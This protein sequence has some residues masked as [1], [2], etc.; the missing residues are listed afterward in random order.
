[1]KVVLL[2]NVP[3]VGERYQVK[4]VAG[5]YARNVLIRQGLALPATAE[6]LKK[7]KSWQA[8]QSREKANEEAWAEEVASKLE[9]Y[10]LSLSGKASPEG[11]LFAGLGTQ[12][13]VAALKKEQG[14]ELKPEAID[15]AKPIK[16]LGIHNLSARL[17]GGREVNFQIL[18]TP[19][20]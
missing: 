3:K 20:E 13:I 4:E 2:K 19:A 7:A 1:M 8:G 17:T 6:N 15:L 16:S 10:T 11:H 12:E 5:G 14:I 18:V 9:G